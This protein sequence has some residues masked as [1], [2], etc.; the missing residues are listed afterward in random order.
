MKKADRKPGW[1]KLVNELLMDIDH[2]M[3]EPHGLG[4]ALI[5]KENSKNRSGKRSDPN[6][7]L[8][9]ESR[10]ENRIAIRK[11]DRGMDPVK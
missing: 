5:D 6:D 11:L 8:D 9:R 1:R 2:S 10:S 7:K 3:G 4:V